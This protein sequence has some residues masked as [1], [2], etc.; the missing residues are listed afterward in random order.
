MYPRSAAASAGPV[1]IAYTS[2]IP[3]V[4][5][6]LCG[7]LTVNRVATERCRLVA[8]HRLGVAPLWSMSHSNQWYVNGVKLGELSV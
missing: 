3:M 1:L 4:G 7:F 8:H 2:N 5:M 6:Y